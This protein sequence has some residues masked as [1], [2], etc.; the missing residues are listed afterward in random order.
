M[1][2]CHHT[3]LSYFS[4]NHRVFY[5]IENGALKELCFVYREGLASYP[6]FSARRVAM[7]RTY[8]ETVVG[9]ILQIASSRNGNKKIKIIAIGLFQWTMKKLDLG[10]ITFYQIIIVCQHIFV[11]KLCCKH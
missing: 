4:R 11:I 6:Q 9:G 3:R 2:L 1:N 7:D 10:C 5:D 8:L